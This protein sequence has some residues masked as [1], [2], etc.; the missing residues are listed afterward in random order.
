M[1]VIA[2]NLQANVIFCQCP[3]PLLL[4]L[5]GSKFSPAGRD[6]AVKLVSAPGIMPL[7]FL[8]KRR[9]LAG[10]TPH[11]SPSPPISQNVLHIHRQTNT[12]PHTVHKDTVFSLTVPTHMQTQG[13]T[14]QNTA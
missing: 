12:C 13:T 6:L 2:Q 1:S 7:V 9:D 14:F 10:N 3:A 11:D 8:E 5:H 4:S